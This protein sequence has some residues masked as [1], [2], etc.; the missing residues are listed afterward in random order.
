MRLTWSPPLCQWHELLYKCKD[1]VHS[2]VL[3]RGALSAVASG[4]HWQ[5]AIDRHCLQDRLCLQERQRG[6]VLFFFWLLT[7]IGFQTSS[8]GKHSTKTSFCLWAWWIIILDTADSFMYFIPTFFCMFH[9]LI[10]IWSLKVR[11][12]FEKQIW[13]I[14]EFVFL[15]RFL[16]PRPQDKGDNIALE[17]A[18]R[19]CQARAAVY[20][21][22][23][24]MTKDYGDD[25]WWW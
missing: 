6:N 15:T 23:L 4:W 5:R 17:T 8:F 22:Q 21:T 12:T 3:L 20:S 10:C 11:P 18:A 14:V 7:S 13:V 9:F 1:M 24:E 16:S 19:A 2:Q 25:M